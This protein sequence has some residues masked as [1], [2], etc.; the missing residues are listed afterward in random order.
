MSGATSSTTPRLNLLPDFPGRKLVYRPLDSG[1]SGIRVI[2][3][4][5]AAEREAP[6][7]CFLRTISIH[8]GKST[9]PYNALSYYW[10]SIENPETV[11]VY[12]GSREYDEFGGSF[13][14]PITSNCALALRQFRAH[15]TAERQPLVVWTDALCINQIDTEERSAQVTIMRD[16]YKA[17]HSVW[18][19]IGGDSLAAEAGLH[20][21]YLRAN[22]KHRSEVFTE[23]CPNARL[24]WM[25]AMQIEAAKGI[26][27]NFED[28][29]QQNIA[30]FASA[31]YWQRGWIIQEA[32]ANDNTYFCYGPARYRMISWRLLADIVRKV[33]KVI[34]E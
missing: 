8:E 3:V 25:A 13:D 7:R 32:T 12:C 10:G 6:L 23:V 28:M 27:D 5:H 29:R 16:I 24:D 22:N 19:W 21:L 31:T 1:I 26:E 11:E 20:N 15:A 9:E 34:P 33:K 14:I 2:V 4:L 18:M 30:V 17:A